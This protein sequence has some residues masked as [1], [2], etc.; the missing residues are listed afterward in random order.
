MSKASDMVRT[1]VTRLSPYNSGLTIAEVMQ[2]YAPVRI[3]KLGSNE[4]PLGPSPTLASMMQ[5]A[6]EMFRLYPDPAGRELRQAIAAK[7]EVGEDQ[8]I[9]G[10]GSEDLLS[11]ISR[12]VL[13]P[14]DAVVTLYPSFPL[15]EDYATLMG[16]SVIGVAVNDD[17]TINVDALIEAV[18]GAPR[19]LLF[20]NPMNPVG[21]WLS[22]SDLSRVLDAVS[23]ETLVVVDEAYAEY[24][25]GDDYA[26]SLSDLGKR[27]RSWI[28]LR[29]FSKAFGLAGLRI[30]CGIV[31]DPEL[32]ALLDRVRTPFNANGVAQAAALAA[33]A[34]EEHLAKVVALAKAERTRVGNFLA[35][36]GLEVAPSRGNFLFFNCRLNAS[37]FAERLLR[38]GVIVKPWKQEG[39]DSYVRVSI[40][41]PAENDHFMAA[42]MQLL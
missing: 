21:S 39:F 5:A 26:S 23:D 3:A 6:A 25:E 24:A 40:G 36:K 13:R 18:R 15:H 32:R 34:D 29:T 41:S 16:A 33:L 12:A 11:V 14:G 4:N 8:I 7:Y 19:M 20:S 31:G 17:L 9:L 22:S 38:E 30:G 10:N 28:V 37:A 35:G 1:E 2:R 27:D 42:L